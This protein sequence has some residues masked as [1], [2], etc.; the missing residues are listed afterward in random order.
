MKIDS[1]PRRDQN[2]RKGGSVLSATMQSARLA[3]TA[4][5]II[6]LACEITAPTWAQ[7]IQGPG[8]G[9]LR[10]SAQKSTLRYV[11]PLPVEDSQR[12]GDPVVLRFDEKYYL[13]VS[14]G[15][16]WSSEDLVHWK[17]QQ[18]SLPKGRFVGA[19]EVF[20]YR[21]YVYMTGNGTGLLRSRNPLGPFEYLGDF[22]DE[23]GAALKPGGGVFDPMVFV[24]EDERVYLYYSGYSVNGIYGVELD[25]ENLTKFLSPPSHLFRF[26]PSHTWEHWGDHNEYHDIAWI[27]APWMTKRQG[28]YY[29]QYSASGTDWKTYAVGLYKGESPLGPF[30]YS[31][32]SPILVQR[33]G[34]INGTGHH[35]IIE[36]PDGTVWALYNVLYRNWNR[37]F[38][39]RIAMDPVGFD[40]EGSM[41]ISG[42]SETPQWAPGV[43]PQPGLGNDSGAIPVSEDKSYT[44]SS[45]APGREAAY[46]IDNN[47]R[48]WWAPAS[49]DVQPWLMLDLACPTAFDVVQEFVIDSARILFTIPA[50][51][52]PQNS[53]PWFRQ[54]KIEVS[55]D[56]R[57][58]TTVVDKT[59]NAADNVIEFD[60]I[61]PIQ[62]RYV[63]LTITGWPKGLPVEVSE[64][65][66]FGKPGASY[67]QH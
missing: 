23:K 45:E 20:T 65:T 60:E 37:M 57:T 59:K 30:T 49:D 9:S 39:R 16:A 11:N 55:S 51:R 48:T 33:H 66:V 52:K 41:F 21:G 32:R 14:E 47:V 34:L 24:D 40:A 46:A 36:A 44:V 56:G 19:P 13:Y 2:C 53:P 58:F 1:L 54:Y 64:F 31:P 8:A 63:K 5:L 38:E 7:V 43:K 25:R 15:M 61:A 3:R 6:V 50:G 22:T 35:C 67:P 28:T 29:L 10:V 12:M 18:V 62:C 4:L 17:H 27:E 26:E 42:P